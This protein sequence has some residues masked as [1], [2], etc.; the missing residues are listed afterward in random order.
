MQELCFISCCTPDFF[1]N[2]FF[3]C[4]MFQILEGGGDEGG[5]EHNFAFVS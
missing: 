4:W 5:Q 3:V 1:F 2:N